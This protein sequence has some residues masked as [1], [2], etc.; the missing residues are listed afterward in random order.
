[1]KKLGAFL[2]ITSLLTLTPAVFA[3]GSDAA[4]PSFKDKRIVSS[5][6]SP[7]THT[8]EPCEGQLGAR[9]MCA[10]LAF[11]WVQMVRYTLFQPTVSM[12]NS[13]RRALDARGSCLR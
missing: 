13:I 10:Q 11:V 3:A 8:L 7:D 1:M 9:E 6:A 5:E 12:Q 2:A 4:T